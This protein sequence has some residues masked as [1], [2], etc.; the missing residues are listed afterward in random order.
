MLLTVFLSKRT[1]KERLS[2][3]YPCPHGRSA[4]TILL[5][6]LCVC[7]ATAAYYAENIKETHMLTTFLGITRG[8]RTS[9]LHR[10]LSMALTCTRSRNLR[11][12]WQRIEYKASTACKTKRFSSSRFKPCRFEPYVPVAF[13]PIYRTAPSPRH[14]PKPH[15]A[16]SRIANLATAHACLTRSRSMAGD[17]K[18]PLPGAHA[19]TFAGRNSDDS[20]SRC[21]SHNHSNSNSGKERLPSP[22]LPFPSPQPPGRRA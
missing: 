13:Y 20:S 16:T 5:Q 21:A 6:R 2:L 14:D 15:P 9:N 18:P 7:K 11:K 8:G 12:K 10:P 3:V 1:R 17:S 4:H 19:Y 22:R